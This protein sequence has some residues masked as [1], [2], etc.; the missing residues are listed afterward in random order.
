MCVRL[1]VCGGQSG[2]LREG[3]GIKGEKGRLVVGWGAEWVARKPGLNIL[4]S[5]LIPTSY[6]HLYICLLISLQLSLSL[7]LPPSLF[8]FSPSL[9]HTHILFF[10]ITSLLVQT[11]TSMH[12]S[13][14][15]SPLIIVF[16]LC[17]ASAAAL[18][19]IIVTRDPHPTEMVVQL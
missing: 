5:A 14:T 3:R 8:T 12:S 11:L 6:Q 18:S 9:T 4:L 7:T 15:H 13:P 17:W 16:T 1:C 2:L 19:Y 10:N